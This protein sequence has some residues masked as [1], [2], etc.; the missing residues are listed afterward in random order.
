MKS[1]NLALL[2]VTLASEI[3]S[4]PDGG[5]LKRLFEEAYYD[6]R[7]KYFFDKYPSGE[8]DIEMQIIENLRKMEEKLNNSLHQAYLQN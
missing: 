6:A 1:K 7:L 4:R 5:E 3:A 8:L 2:L